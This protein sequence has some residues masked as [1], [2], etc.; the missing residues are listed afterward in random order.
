[1]E[2]DKYGQ[3]FGEVQCINPRKVLFLL[4]NKEIARFKECADANIPQLYHQISHNCALKHIKFKHQIIK[5]DICPKV[6]Y[7][8]QAQQ[9]Y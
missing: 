8:L 9:S 7:K 5:I 1:M 2:Q 4:Y 6:Y 3:V